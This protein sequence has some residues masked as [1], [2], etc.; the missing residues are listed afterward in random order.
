MPRA[1][2]VGYTNSGKSSILN[3]LTKA[4]VQVED[5]LFATLD[6]TTRR[7]D[8]VSGGALLLTD[9]V[10]FIRNLP[11]GLIEAFK[12]TLEEASD[13]DLLVHVADA[14]DPEVDKH[15][16]TTEQVLR[17][18]R[19][20][21][22][23]EETSQ[24]RILVLNKTD[25]VEDQNFLTGWLDRHPDAVLTSVK[26]GAG[27]DALHTAIEQGLT[28]ASADRSFRIPDADYAMVALLHREANI[29]EETREEEA[30]LMRCRLPERLESKFEKYRY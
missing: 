25:L 7:L 30:T 26:T 1:A 15:M 2:I 4:E 23:L 17:E 16:A 24:A 14:S 19:A 12:A 22:G 18:L 21:N 8:L 9:T 5:K 27:M 11:H 6:P 29:I 13:A 3:A 20:K 10:G 28:A